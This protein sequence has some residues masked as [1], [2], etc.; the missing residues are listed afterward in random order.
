MN[1]NQASNYRGRQVTIM[2]LGINGGGLASAR[3]FAQAGA[4]VTVTDLR[5]A[6]VLAP[7]VEALQAWPIRYVLGRH[8]MADFT[9]ADLVIKNPGVRPDN[10]FLA[11]ARRVD[12]DIS[13]FLAQ[14]PA[15]V[16]AVTGSKGKS[17]T[18]SAI[19]HI[20]TRSGRRSFLGG[21]ITVSPL[22][23]LEHLTGS[24]VVVLELS[25]WQLGDLRGKSVLQPH[26]AVL[27]HIV[28]DHLDR[29]GTMAAYIADKRLIYANQTA[30]DWL[31]CENDD[32]GR[33]FAAESQGRSLFYGDQL[34]A[35]A[36]GGWL[37]SAGRDR[38]RLPATDPT[39]GP[40]AVGPDS[41]PLTE[42]S[43]LPG[44]LRVPGRHNRLNC[45][46]A[47]LAAWTVGLK[48]DAIRLALADFPGVPHRLEVFASHDGIAWCNDSAATVP[49]AVEAAANS[50]T[51]PLVLITGGTD[52]VLDFEPSRRACAKARQVV[53]LAGSGSDKLRA[54]LEADGTAYQGPFSQLDQALQATLAVVRPGDTVVLSPGCT[55]FGMF[56]NEFDR[57]N[58]FKAAVQALLAAQAGA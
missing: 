24:D 55:S 46:A 22:D 11:A 49:E 27:T 36:L 21:N 28:P 8:E 25:S 14:C 41:G 39:A 31:V 5:G 35:E 9:G 6:D 50:F 51:T 20:L 52:K 16:I 19:H 30:A 40:T 32:W 4:V 26:C 37:D 42:A 1:T 13:L 56:K 12:T 57:G 17:S 2:G 45:L 48:P 18:A 44:S 53:L 7:S 47:G 54:L 23:F 29:Y 10:P 58:S 15:T 3:Y 43:L 38:T 33:S 34:P